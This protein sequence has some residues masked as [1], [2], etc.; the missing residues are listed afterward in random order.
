MRTRWA[1]R[2][3]KIALIGIVAIG[4]CGFVVMSLWNWLAPTIIGAPTI[5]F[6]QALGVLVLCKILFG[7]FRGQ[8]GSG[9]DWKKRMRDRCEQMTPEE[10]EKFLRGIGGWCGQAHGPAEDSG[11]TGTRVGL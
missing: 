1:V 8:P 9:G 11:A 7:G 4:V 10:R 3:P 2:G 6:W 5:G